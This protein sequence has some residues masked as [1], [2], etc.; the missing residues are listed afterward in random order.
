[1][2]L[3]DLLTVSRETILVR[4]DGDGVHRKL[5]RGTEDTDSDFLIT[6]STTR[7]YE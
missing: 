1:M 6:S 7:P 2:E 4:V 3:F 5:V